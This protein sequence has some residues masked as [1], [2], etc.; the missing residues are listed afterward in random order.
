MF[1]NYL[2]TQVQ[3]LNVKSPSQTTASTVRNKWDEESMNRS[4][5]PLRY[6]LCHRSFT[7]RSHLRNHITRVHHCNYFIDSSNDVDPVNVSTGEQDYF[8]SVVSNSVL[9]M[10]TS[11]FYEMFKSYN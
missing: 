9:L 1:Q 7:K 3:Y 8:P 11:V 4:S 2:H 6:H 10:D 5:E